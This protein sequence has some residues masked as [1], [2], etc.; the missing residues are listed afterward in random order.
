M[1]TAVKKAAEDRQLLSG[2]EAIARAAW[3]AGVKV[4]TSYPGTPA[5]EILE[6]IALFPDLHAQF[7]V[8]EKVAMEVAIGAAMS[9]VRALCSMKHV[10]MNVA[11]D[12]FMTYTLT[13]TKGGLVIVV[14][15]DVGLSSSQNEQDSRYWGRFGHMPMLEP[16][17]S[18]EAYEMTKAAFEISERFQTPVILRATTRVCHVKAVAVVGE[19]TPGAKAEFV[20]EAA[21]WVMVPGNARNRLP[22]MAARDVALKAFTE[23][24]GLN[25]IDDGADRRIG[26]VTSGPVAMTL[27]EVFPDAPI[28]K[29]GFSCPLPIERLRAFAATVETVVVAEETEPLIEMEMKAAGIAVRGKEI[30]PRFGELLPHVVG[31]AVRKLLGEAEPPAPAAPAKLFPRP[32]TLCP[33]CPHLAVYHT[34]ARLRKKVVIA[35][36]IGCYSLGAGHPW[37]ALDT[38]VSMGA[39][40]G[41]ALGMDKARDEGDRDKAVLAVIGD[42]TFLHMG[43]QGLL[44]ITYTGGNVTVLLMDNGTTGMTGGQNHPAN[45][46]DLKGAPAPKVD[47]AKLVTALGVAPERVHVVDPY[48]LPVL[49]RTL[50]QEIATPGPSVIITNR[51]CTLIEDFERHQPYHTDEDACTGCGKCIDIGCPAI[52]VARRETAVRKNGREVELAFAHID[53]AVCT[54]CGMCVNVCAS[55]AIVRGETA[56]KEDCR[57]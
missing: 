16:A 40:M 35:G 45:G 52:S 2:N 32:P 34:L 54:G 26:F 17:D 31:P 14:A 33:A 47:F 1:T 9:G 4:A 42:S 44:D 27:R 5:T 29:L 53:T 21:R 25:R 41:V 18:Q 46:R 55:E 39:S 36:D 56:A 22:L 24:T 15:D 7:S 48:Q 13:G 37:G 11:A 49:D 20:P 51:P 38:C 12:A 6:A 3:E 50:R 43:M 19:R 10:G 28:F 57:S 8:N 23:E 30:L